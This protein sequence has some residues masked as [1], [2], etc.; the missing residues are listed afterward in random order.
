MCLRH[1]VRQRAIVDTSLKTCTSF[2]P[3]RHQFNID[4]KC[5]MVQNSNK[6]TCY[7]VLNFFLRALL[8]F[9]TG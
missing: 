9:L 7:L 3:A 8:L 1:I 6:A 2:L 5:G 4:I